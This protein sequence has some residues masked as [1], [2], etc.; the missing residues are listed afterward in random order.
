M[1]WTTSRRDNHSKLVERGYD[2]QDRKSYRLLSNTYFSLITLFSIFFLVGCSSSAIISKKINTD[3]ANLNEI[4]KEMVIK[5]NHE[6]E[7]E[8][9]LNFTTKWRPASKEEDNHPDNTVEVKLEVNIAEEKQD[10]RLTMKF[11]KRSSLYSTDPYNKTYTDIIIIQNDKIYLKK[12]K[13]IAE[14]ESEFKKK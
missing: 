9:G 1:K 6:I 7:S 12:K 13:K 14:I 4:I 5:E 10:S 2:L 11:M 8:D 3:P